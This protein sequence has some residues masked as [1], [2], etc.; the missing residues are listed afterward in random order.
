LT[1]FRKYEFLAESITPKPARGGQARQRWASK[2]GGGTQA[3][4]VFA[5][6]G[7][8]K[9]LFLDFST[10]SPDFSEDFSRNDTYY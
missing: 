1:N 8:E 7:I 6:G 4:D 10:P 3:Q 9:S 2:F 5:K